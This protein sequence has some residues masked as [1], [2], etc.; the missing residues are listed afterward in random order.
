MEK[1]SSIKN[2]GVLRLPPGFRFHPT[3][4][5]LVVQYLRRKVTGLP[6]PASVI[7]E[8]DVCKS[9]P[10]DLPGDCESEMYF[11]S[12]REA[13]YPNGNRSN[14]STGSGYWKATGLDKQIGKKKLVVG[15]KKTLVFYK[16]KPPNGTRTNW[17]L[18]EYRLVDSQQDSL[19]GQNMNWVLCRV[20]LK[21]RSNS[22]SKRKEDEKEEVENEK[23]TETE[24]EREEENKKSTCPI[25]Y[26]FMRKDTKKKRR[27]RR[28]CDLNLTPATCCCC[29]SSTSSS[30][31]CSSA[32]THTS[33]NDNRQEISYRENKFCLFL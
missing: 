29:S 28:C 1:R 5:E 9:D 26:D 32:L 27:R 11:F 21:K 3:D 15:M 4:E 33:S 19:Y 30:S 24:R 31:V 12:T 7:P 22:N 6:L 18:H 20:F 23:E 8:T 17:V 2:R 14:R 16:G 13:K 10:W 25:F